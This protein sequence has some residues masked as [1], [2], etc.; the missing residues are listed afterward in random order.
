MNDNIG[1]GEIARASADSI[2]NFLLMQRMAQQF[3][4]LE[5]AARATGK[6]TTWTEEAE[7]DY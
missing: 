7:Y 2:T 5:K 6:A 1:G 4:E 3:R